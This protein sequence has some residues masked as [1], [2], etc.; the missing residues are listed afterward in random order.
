MKAL[1]LVIVVLSVAVFAT[2]YAIEDPG[3]VLIARKP[4]SI[5]LPLTLFVPL[6]LLAFVV[7]HWVWRVVRLTW[8]I[9][10]DVASWRVRR[11]NKKA[12]AALIRGLIHLAEANWAKAQGELIAGLQYGT[13]PLI[14][15]LGAACAAQAMGD[16]EKR[17][18]YIAAAQ[19]AAPEQTLAI[20]MTQAHLYSWTAQHEQALATLSELRARVPKHAHVLQ[21]LMNTYVA[22]DD[23]ASLV[24][25][26]PE[27]RRHE[28]LSAGEL[29][30]LELQAH[31]ELLILV[32]PA[33]GLEL[34]RRAW[35]SM[36]RALR[37]HP[38]TVAIYARHLIRQK[39]VNEAEALL[40]D[41]IRRAW[42]DELVELYG[43]ALSD[44]PSAQLETAENWLKGRPEN[45]SLLLTVGRLAIRNQLWGKARSYLETCVR[46][47]PTLEIY[48]ELGALMEQL[49]EPQKALEYYRRGLETLTGDEP[50][51]PPT[52]SAVG[53]LRRRAS[54]G[55]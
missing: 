35:N 20:A 55:A 26:M 11:S 41:A 43:R 54:A 12:R 31:R 49:G 25:L 21:L 37:Q 5:E 16:T 42:N 4:Y 30:A 8:L 7:L 50:A 51:K 34:L 27:L 45:P 19:K 46:R 33:G 18:E 10:Q 23:W 15:Y 48:R 28:V 52:L 53:R 14:N 24:E 6:L 32:R 36:P 2:L 1:A 39:Q 29:D 38:S 13:S 22:L 3:Y 47:R 9:P 40:R 17:D 44:D